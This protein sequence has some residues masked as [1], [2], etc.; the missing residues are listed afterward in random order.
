MTPQFVEVRASTAS[1]GAVPVKRHVHLPV[2]MRVFP[3]SVAV[4]RDAPHRLGTCERLGQLKHVLLQKE[5]E[6][7]GVG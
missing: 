3:D 5:P 6:C 7:R 2:A 4:S 1:V